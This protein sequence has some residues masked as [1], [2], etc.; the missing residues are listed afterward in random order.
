MCSRLGIRQAF[1]QAHRPQANGRAEVA[2]KQLITHL[3]KLH[4]DDGINW[5]QILPRVL[6]QLHDQ[7]RE[8][9]ISPYKLLFG[10]EKNLSGL[11]FTPE[12]LCSDAQD[13]FNHIDEMDVKIS[14]IMNAQH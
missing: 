3:R 2:G 11:P 4:A 5:V 9:G 1:S 10:I 14:Q 13:F 7:P 12:R 8:S 6:L